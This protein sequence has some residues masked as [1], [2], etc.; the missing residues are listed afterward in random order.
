MNTDL[1]VL[2]AFSG[3]CGMKFGKI[4]VFLVEPLTNGD[5]LE[6]RMKIVRTSYF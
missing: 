5:A 6:K 4:C 3:N 1:N 2:M